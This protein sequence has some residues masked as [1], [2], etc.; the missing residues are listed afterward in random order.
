MKTVSVDL[1]DRSY[2]IF[3]GSGILR[4]TPLPGVDLFGRHVVIATNSIVAAHYLDRLKAALSDRDRQI[5]VFEFADG[6]EQK[7]L[8]SVS[9]MIDFMIDA[10]CDRYVT[11]VALGGGVVGDMAGFVSACY[12]RGTPYVQ[13]PTTLLAQ[14]DSAVGGKTAVNHSRGKNLIGAFH[15]PQCVIADTDTLSTLNEREFHAG[16]AEVIKYGVIY[17]ADFFDWLEANRAAVLSRDANALGHIIARSCEIKAEIVRQD[18]HE[19][20]VRAILNLGHT[21]GHAI[22][23]H[24]R[25]K[26]WLHGEAVAAG[27]LLAANMAYHC[28]HLSA[29]NRDRICRLITDYGL[30]RKLPNDL[31]VDDFIHYM[32]LD[33]KVRDGRIRLVLPT[34]IGHADV[35]D[36]YPPSVL[37]ST[38][39]EA[40]RASVATAPNDTQVV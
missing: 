31:G 2:D 4:N 1:G 33:K 24:T 16:L 35:F 34:A 36:Q 8:E 11:V 3:V 17:D 38:L 10:Q 15:Q 37:R 28:S 40:S 13:I 5:H 23:T 7:N 20:G 21:F 30:D 19:H 39:Q 14:V 18:E 26:T 12:Q 27:I 25:Y 29:S 32:R 22:E 6:E 9:R